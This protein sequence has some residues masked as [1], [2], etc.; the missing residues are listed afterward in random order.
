MKKRGRQLKL[1]AELGA[2]LGRL[3]RKSGGGYLN[4]RVLS[5]WQDLSEGLL[6][7]HTTGAHVRGDE[8]VIFVD[9]NTWASHFSAMS[10][11]LRTALNERI[12]EELISSLRFIVSRRVAERDRLVQLE[13][14]TDDFY[15]AEECDSIPLSDV[16]LAQ[17]RASVAEIPDEELRE[18]VFRATVKDLEWKKGLAAQKEP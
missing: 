4:A 6:A 9:G 11:Q 17:I 5:A 15:G 10:E 7:S 18:A 8:L 16:E 14:E 3:D 12:G 13:Q 1:G 2:V